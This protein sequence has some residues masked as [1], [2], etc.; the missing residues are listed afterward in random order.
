MNDFVAV[1]V[2]LAGRY[3]Y[4]RTKYAAL[5]LRAHMCGSAVGIRYSPR[6][7]GQRMLTP[8][9][10]QGPAVLGLH[11]STLLWMLSLSE[12]PPGLSPLGQESLATPLG[13]RKVI[14]RGSSIA[15]HEKLLQKH[16]RRGIQCGHVARMKKC[17]DD[18][19]E[20]AFF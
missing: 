6:D 8:M 1:P 15:Y 11:S 7:S 16:Y 20:K 5:L 4:L 18:V 14:A 13:D 17:D 19:H 3:S 2:N 9:T 10:T 12:N